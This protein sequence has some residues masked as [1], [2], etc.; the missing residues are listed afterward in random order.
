MAVSKVT[1][2]ARDALE[3]AKAREFVGVATIENGASQ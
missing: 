3:I 2:T 1:S